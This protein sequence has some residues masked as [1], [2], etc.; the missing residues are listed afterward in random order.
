MKLKDRLIGAFLGDIIE[1]KV[2]ERL[3]AAS[4]A[5]IEKEE[6]GWRRLTGD[7]PKK[8]LSPLKQDR[9]LEI[10]FYLWENNPLANWIIEITKDFIVGDG[11]PYEA[12]NEDIKLLFDD[13]W[14]DSIN[15]MDLY[16]EKYV[17]ELFMYGEL[18]FPVFTAE[19]TGKLRL[20]Y[21]DPIQIKEAITDPDN[22]KV[23]IGI[24]LKDTMGQAGRRLKTIYPEDAEWSLSIAAQALRKTYTDG[25]CFFFAIN[26]VT[27]S[28]RG[29]SELLS[30][31]DWLDAYEQFLFDYSDKWPLL[32]SFVWDILVTGGDAAAIQEQIKAF[33]KKA[34]SIYGHNEKITLTP[35]TPDLKSIDVAEGARLFR[36]HILG[37]KNIPEHWYGGGGDVNRATSIEMGTPA[38]KSLSSKQKY[39]KYILETI[40]DYVIAKALKANYLRVDEFEAYDFSII[41]PEMSSKD[42]S[43]YGALIQQ[44]ATSL[45]SA[46]MQGWVDKNNARKIFAVIVGYL[47]IEM[48]LEEMKK[49]IKEKEDKKGYEDYEGSKV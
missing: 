29:R 36:N 23:V 32:N 40:L 12:K 8:D 17:R 21:I 3:K 4:A 2:S 49:T 6:I 20:G 13:F 41:T 33:T 24:I 44:V 14:F 46:E 10:A 47:G 34:G 39:I 43:K 26:N 7:N 18:C 28:P 42:V 27:N 25:E 5:D 11:L 15:R 38:F 1:Q 48:D 30:I 37:A 19:Q 35:S 16:L 45:V 22:V 31:A 9:M